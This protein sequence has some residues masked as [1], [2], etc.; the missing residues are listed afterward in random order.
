MRAHED[1]AG[2]QGQQEARL[3]MPH[4]REHDQRHQAGGQG[5][6]VH[7]PHA[8]LPRPRQAADVYQ[9]VGDAHYKNGRERSEEQG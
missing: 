4:Q 9:P 7:R 2:Q 8:G 3:L 6:G 1:N 5:Q